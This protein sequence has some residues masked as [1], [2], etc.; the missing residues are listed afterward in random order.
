MFEFL[1][2][3][4]TNPTCSVHASRCS[5]LWLP[6]WTL[7]FLSPGEPGWA[8][9]LFWSACTS[10]EQENRRDGVSTVWV[11]LSF[12]LLLQP[13]MFVYSFCIE[14][15]IWKRK[16][17]FLK[18]LANHLESLWVPFQLACLTLLRYCLGE[19]LVSRLQLSRAESFGKYLQALVNLQ[20]EAWFCPL[21]SKTWVC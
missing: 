6:S 7:L 11:F 3:L 1:S 16:K 9:F 21:C 13:A 2:L 8:H 4:Y 20:P 14:G 5:F 12:S 15:F 10:L 19:D 18:M 17:N